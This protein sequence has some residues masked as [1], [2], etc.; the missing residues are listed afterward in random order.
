MF[1]YFYDSS[2]PVEASL[3]VYILRFSNC[4]FSH[5]C[6]LADTI[7]KMVVFPKRAGRQKFQSRAGHG[8]ADNLHLNDPF[9]QVNMEI[10]DVRLRIAVKDFGTAYY[11]SAYLCYITAHFAAVSICKEKQIPRAYLC[12]DMLLQNYV[13]ALLP[14][15]QNFQ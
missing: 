4:T 15:L 10:I 2:F 12:R 7:L 9:V 14:L 11:L 13:L 3:I 1:G 6:C 8:S 5:C